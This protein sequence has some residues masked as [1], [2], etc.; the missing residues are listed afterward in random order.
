MNT[1]ILTDI[2]FTLDTEQLIHQLRLKVGSSHIAEVQS[3]ARDAEVI[4]H[5]KAMYK[6]AYIENK[7]END[8]HIE[9]IQFTSRVLRVNLDQAHRVFPYVA[10]CGTELNAWAAGFTDMLQQYW[11]D[12]IKQM[13][14][15]AATTFLFHR[16][17]TSYQLASHATMNPGSLADWPLAQQHPLFTL[18]GDPQTAISVELTTSYLMI[19]N[20]S[21]SGILFTTETRYENCQLCP[22]EKCPG[23]R[24]PYNAQLYSE[25]YAQK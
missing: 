2:P 15:R 13:A 1:F 21:V 18:L 11:A 10:T 12:A 14:L 23:R 17:K 7:G 9:G 5:P 6:I 25:K 24:T 16:L 4:A 8:V 20:K 3:L 19:P 22:R